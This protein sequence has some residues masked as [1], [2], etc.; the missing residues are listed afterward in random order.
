[1]MLL[2]EIMTSMICL[3]AIAGAA[4]LAASEYTR[5]RKEKQMTQALCRALQA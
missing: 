5:G 3:A 4:K 1:M 2:L